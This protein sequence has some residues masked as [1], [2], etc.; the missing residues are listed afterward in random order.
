MQGRTGALRRRA[1]ARAASAFLIPALLLA[2]LARAASTDP[3]PF[4]STYA[5]EARG[6]NGGTAKLTFRQA[7]A[8]HWTYSSELNAH[9][10]FRLYLPGTRRQMSEMRIEDG[11]VIPQHYVDEDGTDKKDKDTDVRFDWTA[12]RV[13]GMAENRKVDDELRPGTQ[14]IL[15]LQIAMMQELRAG[16]TPT[17]FVLLD[18][19]EIKDFDYIADGA[20]QLQT[21][22]GTFETKI[23]RSKRPDSERSMVYWCA[24]ELG[25][26]PLKVENRRGTKVQWAL[27]MTGLKRD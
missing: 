15:S 21:P 10:L 5:F 26:L 13:T 9:G 14:D 6:F 12:N 22:F 23:F 7:D 24:P 3:S 19:E 11:R 17:K 16:R 8:Q 4:E 27:R 18:R 1:A 2:G 25:W 20:E